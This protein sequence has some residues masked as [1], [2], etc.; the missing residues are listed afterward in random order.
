MKKIDI[1]KM[2]DPPQVLKDAYDRLPPDEQ[3]LYGLLGLGVAFASD[4]LPALKKGKK[5]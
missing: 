5:K 1:K 2:Q 4:N 3:R